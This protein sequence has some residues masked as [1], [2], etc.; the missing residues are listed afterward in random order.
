MFDFTDF[1]TLEMKAA[2]FLVTFVPTRKY[3]ITNLNICFVKI[4]YNSV[5]VVLISIALGVVLLT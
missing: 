1:P 3:G 5:R 4:F 2:G